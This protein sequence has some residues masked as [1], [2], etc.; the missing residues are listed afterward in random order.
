[1]TA[2]RRC[3]L[4]GGPIRDSDAEIARFA[5]FLRKVHAAREAGVPLR[6]AFEAI[7]NDEYPENDK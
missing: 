4:D 2:E 6:E 7:Y 1:M 3:N 5:I